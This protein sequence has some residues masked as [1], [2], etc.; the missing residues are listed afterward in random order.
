[1]CIVKQY[2]VDWTFSSKSDSSNSTFIVTC[3]CKLLVKDKDDEKSCET[4]A[5]ALIIKLAKHEAAKKMLSLVFNYLNNG[6]DLNY[7]A[8]NVDQNKETILENKNIVVPKELVVSEDLELEE[9]NLD[10]SLENGVEK[11]CNI[12]KDKKTK[13]ENLNMELESLQEPKQLDNLKYDPEKAIDKM[14]MKMKKKP[15]KNEEKSIEEK[16]LKNV[17]QKENKVIEIDLEEELNEENK[18]IGIEDP[19]FELNEEELF[20]II[21]EIENAEL[22]LDQL[23]QLDIENILKSE[24]E[25]GIEKMEIDLKENSVAHE[26]EKSNFQNKKE[27]E[28]SD[29]VEINSREEKKIKISVY[30]DTM[31]KTF[32][33]DT[34]K[35]IH[36]KIDEFILSMTASKNYQN[37]YFIDQQIYQLGNIMAFINVEV[38]ST[39]FVA[40][41]GKFIRLIHITTIPE[42][43]ESEI[44]NDRAN[45]GE[46][47]L[48]NA[49]DKLKK[50]LIS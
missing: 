11:E 40:H 15:G 43:V 16:S 27:P 38:N 3:C 8:V 36:Q 35:I 29:N 32:G 37:P 31:M 12:F 39:V 2:K 24:A 28:K 4:F 25:N 6:V 48:M 49:I 45:L 44:G 9:I 34:R 41:D 30:H 26:N 20:S 10:N 21:L 50:L 14:K 17:E 19:G 46:K 47:A 33:F 23:D 1:M 42:I 13:F 7:L 18:T 5:Q 22:E